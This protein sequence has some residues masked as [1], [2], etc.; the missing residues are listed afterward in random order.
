MTPFYL[1]LLVGSMAFKLVRA[2]SFLKPPIPTHLISSDGDHP[3]HHITLSLS[4]S[5]Y[6]HLISPHLVFVPSWALCESFFF[7]FFP[8]FF[9]FTLDNNLLLLLSCA[10]IIFY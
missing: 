1:T 7:L 3:G 4:S 5:I 6:H 9:C 8:P 10:A 2:T